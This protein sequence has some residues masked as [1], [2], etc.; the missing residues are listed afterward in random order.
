L[1]ESQRRR[2]TVKTLVA[3]LWVL[4]SRRSTFTSVSSMLETNQNEGEAFSNGNA[5]NPRNWVQDSS[6]SSKLQGKSTFILEPP[7]CTPLHHACTSWCVLEKC[8]IDLSPLYQ[9]YRRMRCNPCLPLN[10]LCNL[11][12][13]N[14]RSLERMIPEVHSAPVCE[15]EWFVLC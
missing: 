10:T 7:G 5:C 1:S 8:C 3:V 9:L 6:I 12:I 13:R 15:E 4:N 11:M 2:E 14:H